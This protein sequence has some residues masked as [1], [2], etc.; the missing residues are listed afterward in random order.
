MNSKQQGAIGVAEAIR[1]YV[2]NGYTVFVPVSDISRFDLV[3][4]KDGKLQRVEVKSCSAIDNAFMLR[5]SGGNQSWNKKSKYL[6]SKDCDRVF[7]YN[8]NS[9]NSKEF[10]ISELE[11][12]ASIRFS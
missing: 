4:E 2:Q 8:L 7:L 5:T 6:S 10:D 1:Y 12:R 11:G 9:K 3:V